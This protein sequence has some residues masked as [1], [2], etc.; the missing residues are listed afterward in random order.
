M[1]PLRNAKLCRWSSVWRGRTRRAKIRILYRCRTAHVLGRALKD[2][3][4]EVQH[5]DIGAHRHDEFHVVFYEQ[6]TYLASRHGSIQDATEGAGLCR[7][8][9]SR[10]LIQEDDPEASRQAAS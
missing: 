6:N 2:Q 1:T 8:Q 7:I 9:P 4:A 5:I 10:R 3:F